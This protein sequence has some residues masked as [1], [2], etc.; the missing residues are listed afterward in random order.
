MEKLVSKKCSRCRKSKT[1]NNFHLNPNG[2]LRA[3]CRDCRREADRKRRSAAAS[4]MDLADQLESGEDP[5]V[6][7]EEAHEVMQ[8]LESETL[9]ESDLDETY[10]DEFGN[11]PLVEAVERITGR[12]VNPGSVEIPED[13]FFKGVTGKKVQYKV[14]AKL[15]TVCILSDVHIP[16][17]DKL[18]WAVVLK[19][20]GE[21]QPDEIIL[22]G[23]FLEL[24]SCSQH[25]GAPDITNLEADF[26]AGRQAIEEL[27]DAAPAAKIT[28]LEGNHETRLV[29]F[30]LAKAPSLFGALTIP[31]GLHLDKYG[32][33][34][35]G[36]REQPISRG[37]ID[38]LHGHQVGGGRLAILPK[39]HAA[40]IVDVYGHSGRTV[41]IGHSHREGVHSKPGT[42]GNQ[43]GVALGALRTMNPEWMHGHLG[44]WVH[45]FGIGYV[46]PGGPSHLYA[47]T[48]HDGS[49]VWNGKLYTAN[50]GT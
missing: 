7:A 17:N 18:V 41:V 25:G 9:D 15:W 38:I 42:N 35:V 5:N 22:N 20:I 8:E 50:S 24:S 46:W 43:R 2:T 21:N 4:L 31:L 1:V 49:F 27:R 33:E 47:V 11:N 6:V 39:H 14:G 48:I 37:T 19:W 44:G 12:H 23:D 34:Y 32:V 16:E 45:Q 3:D 28:Y 10:D 13:T 36:E 26:E 40:K 29:R 30:I